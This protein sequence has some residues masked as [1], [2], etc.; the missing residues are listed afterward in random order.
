MTRK[1]ARRLRRL[2]NRAARA[3]AH[4]NLRHGHGMATAWHWHRHFA[5]LLPIATP[6]TVTRLMRYAAANS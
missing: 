3:W 4:N 6:E 5:H 2:V 1:R